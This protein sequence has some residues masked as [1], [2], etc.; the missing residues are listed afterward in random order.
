MP[1]EGTDQRH[2]YVAQTRPRQEGIAELNLQR[3]GYTCYLPRLTT[4]KRLRG[5]WQSVTEPLFP[6]YIFV[7]VDLG[8]GHI[9]PLFSTKG[10]RSLVRFGTCYL[11]FADTAVDYLQQQEQHQHKAAT[12]SA[13]F[14]PG[15]AV[16]ILEGPFAGLNAV[17]KCTKPKDRVEILIQLLGTSQTLV[18]AQDQLSRVSAAAA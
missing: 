3:Q 2:W 11:P 1:T 4:R 16:A 15:E 18:I 10:I 14:E 7:R 17:Y 5:H 8:T 9:A 13:L 6:G 12:S